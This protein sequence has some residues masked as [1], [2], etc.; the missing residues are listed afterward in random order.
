MN[1]LLTDVTVA[2]FEALAGYCRHPRTL[3]FATEVRWLQACEE[4][5]LVVIIRDHEDN[6]FAALLL[7]QDLKER[8]RFFHMSS[9][10]AS[11]EEALA[12]VPELVTTA[13][14]ELETDRAR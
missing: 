13:M 14:A 7:A 11:Q 1:D 9:F 3:L 4:T 10:F 5:I 2:R 6:D 8:Y 12:T